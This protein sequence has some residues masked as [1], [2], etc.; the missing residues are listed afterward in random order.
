MSKPI[1]NYSKSP[2]MPLVRFGDDI[3]MIGDAGLDEVV[4]IVAAKTSGMGHLSHSRGRD[5]RP[6]LSHIRVLRPGV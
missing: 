3:R 2:A 1:A 6:N 5:E 4:D